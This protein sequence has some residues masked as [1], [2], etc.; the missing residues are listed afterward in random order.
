MFKVP[1]TRTDFWLEKIGSN[2]TRDAANEKSLTELG[3]RT[4]YVWECKLR[5]KGSLD[6]E[7]ILEQFRAWLAS[8]DVIGELSIQ[9]DLI[10]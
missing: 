6:D 7:A 1:A 10:G 4:F 9:A 2:R 5:G 3:W 8:P